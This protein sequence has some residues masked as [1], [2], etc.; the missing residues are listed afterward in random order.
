MDEDILEKTKAGLLENGQDSVRTALLHFSDMQIDHR[1]EY[2]HTKWINVCAY[3]AAECISNLILLEHEPNSGLLEFEDDEFVFPHL[4]QVLSTL[5]GRRFSEVLSNSERMLCKMFGKLS[6]NRHKYMHRIA[7]VDADMSIAAVA[8][9]GI[10]RLL[11]NHKGIETSDMLDASPPIESDMAS[12]IKTKH[13]RTYERYVTQFLKEEKISGYL[14]HCPNCDLHTV[15]N[16]SCWACFE[17]FE[18]V[19]CE[20]C[21]ESTNYLSWLP[22]SGEKSINCKN[23]GVK[24]PIS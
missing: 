23:C 6:K 16:T 13:A 4:D 10:L 8:L 2:H 3:H 20:D 12:V 22:Q 1:G 14:E 11:K 17:E 9:L 15:H 7:P 19:Y 5:K 24:L 18:T 21:D